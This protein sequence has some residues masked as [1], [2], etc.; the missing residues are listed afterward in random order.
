MGFQCVFLPLHGRQT[1]CE[2]H[3]S[4]LTKV[5]TSQFRDK[6]APLSHTVESFIFTWLITQIIYSCG[7]KNSGDIGLVQF[8]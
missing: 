8:L 3:R 5:G 1:L 6:W 2:V 7:K 4:H